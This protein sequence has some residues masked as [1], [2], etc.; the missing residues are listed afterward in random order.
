MT[1]ETIRDERL[2]LVERLRG[3]PDGEWDRPSL[4][5]GCEGV[6]VLAER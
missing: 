5:E 3:L 2:R 4:Y 1:L 6:Q